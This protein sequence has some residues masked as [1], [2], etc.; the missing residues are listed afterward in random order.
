MLRSCFESGLA[1]T[2]GTPRGQYREQGARD[3]VTSTASAAL[4]LRTPGSGWLS[5]YVGFPVP[6]GTVEQRRLEAGGIALG[7]GQTA[8]LEWAVKS[9]RSKAK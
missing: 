2:S 6:A 9:G 7:E 5:A 4:V 8:G 1:G 3:R